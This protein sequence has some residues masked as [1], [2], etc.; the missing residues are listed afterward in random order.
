[1]IPTKCISRSVN[2]R[3][4][5]SGQFCH[6]PI[7]SQWEK[8][9]L[10]LFASLPSQRWFMYYLM[11]ED[12]GDVFAS[13]LCNMHFKPNDVIRGHQQSLII[14]REGF[15]TVPF[16]A[17]T[18]PPTDTVRPPIDTSRPWPCDRPIFERPCAPQIGKLDPSTN[19]PSPPEMASLSAPQTAPNTV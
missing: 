10:P 2:I 18:A 14:L 11:I 16:C 1:M 15:Q 17:A 9:Q 3:N 13:D 19:S 6:V 5:R 12:S 8:S 4:L 7:I